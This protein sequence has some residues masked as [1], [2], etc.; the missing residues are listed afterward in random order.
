MG[1]Y[2]SCSKFSPEWPSPWRHRSW[3][4]SLLWERRALLGRQ[5]FS[6][7]SSQMHKSW[8]IAPILPTFSNEPMLKVS[9]STLYQTNKRSRHKHH[10]LHPD[11]SLFSSWRCVSRDLLQVIVYLTILLLCSH[12]LS[13]SHG[14][15]FSYSLPAHTFCW[16]NSRQTLVSWV[17]LFF[18]NALFG[19]TTFH[20]SPQITCV[21]YLLNH[22]LNFL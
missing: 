8:E 14:R 7:F 15:N 1:N 19:S 6:S 12:W 10:S 2:N 4:P 16:L 20:F 13:R 11:L 9:F 18:C 5:H 3:H 17:D 22:Q 21:I